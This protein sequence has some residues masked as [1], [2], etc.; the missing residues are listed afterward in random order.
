[1]GMG[2]QVSGF[3]QYMGSEIIVF[4]GIKDRNLAGIRITAARNFGGS[5]IKIDQKCGIRDQIFG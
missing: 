5:G 1:M 3:T 2:Y 4:K